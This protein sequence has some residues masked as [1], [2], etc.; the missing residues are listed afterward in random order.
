MTAK[1]LL[2]LAK[3]IYSFLKEETEGPEDGAQIV[4]MLHVMLWLSCKD[5]VTSTE[6]MLKA[7]CSDFQVNFDR[8]WKANLNA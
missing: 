5:D 7:Y 1:E 4:L 3:Y 8:N 2:P 6:A